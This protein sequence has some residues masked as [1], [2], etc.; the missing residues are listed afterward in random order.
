MH[1]AR[2]ARATPATEPLEPAGNTG[3]WCPGIECRQPAKEVAVGQPGPMVVA[4]EGGK[5]AG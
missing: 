3:V 5:V 1:L 2:A 4:V